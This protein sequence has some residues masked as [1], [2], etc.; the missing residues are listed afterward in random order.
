M[1][2]LYYIFIYFLLLSGCIDFI[3][4]ICY[5]LFRY[6]YNNLYNLKYWKMNRQPI[7]GTIKREPLVTAK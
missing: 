4:N 1:L 2:I 3:Q 6:L 7:R 5:D